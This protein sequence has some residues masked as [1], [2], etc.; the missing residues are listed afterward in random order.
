MVGSSASR[1]SFLIESRSVGQCRSQFVRAISFN[2]KRMRS[3]RMAKGSPTERSSPFRLFC[4]MARSD[5]M[6]VARCRWTIVS[7][8]AA[9]QSHPTVRKAR[10]SITSSSPMRRIEQRRTPN[11]GMLP[12]R[13][14]GRASR[15]TRLIESSSAKPSREVVTGSLRSTSPTPLADPYD[16]ASRCAEHLPRSRICSS[17]LSRGDAHLGRCFPQ[18]RNA[19]S[20]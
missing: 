1:R 5:L 14:G 10:P 12:F 11:S 13:A 20:Q 7:S 3:P 6:T 8:S 4:K 19:K 18:T 9:T 17:S 2:S 15:S 16:S